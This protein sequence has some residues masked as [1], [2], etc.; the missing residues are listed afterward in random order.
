MSTT[1]RI[2]RPTTNHQHPRT[3]HTD[4]NHNDHNKDSGTVASSSSTTTLAE[5][6]QPSPAATAGDTNVGTEEPKDPP[7]STT[8]HA[9]Q[10]PLST[11]STNTTK[12]LEWM[13]LQQAIVAQPIGSMTPADWKQAH[14]WMQTPLH[15]L[16]DRY[17][18]QGKPKM[19][20][21]NKNH[22][23][24]QPPTLSPSTTSSSSSFVYKTPL[25]LQVWDRLIQEIQ[26]TTAAK[27]NSGMKNKDDSSS[28]TN[29][30]NHKFLPPWNAND[31]GG[32]LMSIL[33][34]WK[35][36]SMQAITDNNNHKNDK[37]NPN[38]NHNHNH[39]LLET[40]VQLWDRLVQASQAGLW[41][42]LDTPMVPGLLL[43]V[44]A[45]QA[46]SAQDVQDLMNQF[47]QVQADLQ[48]QQQQQAALQQQQQPESPTKSMDQ[49]DESHNN[50]NNAP[51]LSLSN[52]NNNTNNNHRPVVLVDA[53]TYKTVVL[54][55][56]RAGQ[57]H[58]CDRLVRQ[59]VQQQQ[60]L[61]AG[62]GIPS[63]TTTST[64]TV[65]TASHVLNVALT[66][67]TQQ[68][69]AQQ[70]LSNHP[71]A[72]HATYQAWTLYQDLK[73]VCTPDLVSFHSLLNILA[74][75]WRPDLVDQLFHDGQQLYQQHNRLDLRPDVPLY[76]VRLQA[77]A[78]ILT[79]A[80]SRKG[81]LSTTT[82]RKDQ[83][84]R[85]QME[86]KAWKTH[87]HKAPEQAT[88]VLREMMQVPWIG[89]QDSATSDPSKSHSD[90][91]V[92]FVDHSHNPP[93]DDK[94]KHTITQQQRQ[95][96]QG[97]R[98][99][100]A[101]DV[102]AVQGPNKLD[103][104]LVLKCWAQSKRPDAGVQAEQVMRDMLE[105]HTQLQQRQDGD[106]GIVVDCFPN[107][108]SWNHVLTAHL[109]SGAPGSLERVY[110]L[111]VELKQQQQLLLQQQPVQGTD[112]AAA[113]SLGHVDL[114]V[115]LYTTVL[116]A[117]V[118]SRDPMALERAEEL[119]QELKRQEQQQQ[120]ASSAVSSTSARIHQVDA[121][122]YQVMVQVAHERQDPQRI[123]E[124]FHEMKETRR[125]Q[126]LQYCHCLRVQSWAAAG[127][128]EHTAAALQEWSHQASLPPRIQSPDHADQQR[129]LHDGGRTK[130]PRSQDYDSVL[131]AWSHCAT[132]RPDAPAQAEAE[133]RRR[134]NQVQNPDPS[135]NT[136]AGAMELTPSVV[137]YTHVLTTLARSGA[138]QAGVQAL[139]LLRELQQLA[140]GSH[141]PNESEQALS[142]EENANYALAYRFQPSLDTYVQ[143]ISALC[144]SRNQFAVS[145]P[146]ANN[147]NDTNDNSTTTTTP[148]TTTSETTPEEAIQ[149]L[150]TELY[151]VPHPRLFGATTSSSTP[152]NAEDVI[153]SFDKMMGDIQGSLYL[154]DP[155]QKERLLQQLVP[156][157]QAIFQEQGVQGGTTTSSMVQSS[158]SSRRYPDMRAHS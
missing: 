42:P 96:R 112:A 60:Q 75:Q 71:S 146:Q 102:T 138:P 73:H 20:K 47:L 36:E 126:P 48:Q 93:Q 99:R 104:D 156:L 67:W 24:T 109:K 29:S 15:H 65:V 8:P 120:A 149:G 124:L 14:Q 66:A 125:I 62:H 11:T 139:R 52:N 91:W 132:T 57:A 140:K 88:H 6:N 116:Q 13:Q 46:A 105:Y 82:T 134:W 9:Q 68:A 43:S 50:N 136:N 59:L 31:N 4:H 122:V 32:L 141:H 152:M 81:G 131:Q 92:P 121:V 41:T 77:W 113:A 107:A 64:N 1:T 39:T 7:L 53:W 61:E 37:D 33:K 110:Q 145:T 74:K 119:F 143:V 135:S 133:L 78:T 114:D 63:S 12:S 28:T 44:L 25:V 55:W 40:P 76:R 151:N 45:H 80:S 127:Y 18:K 10:T 35:T 142:R 94:K 16:T 155:A 111:F 157:R 97:R 101:V 2:L 56:R 100:H 83:D 34:D 147:H 30:S 86:F 123:E 89:L 154:R 129:P 158:S 130:P 118:R 148:A 26:A 70:S 153:Q 90:S 23:Q 95:R 49:H 27:T 150:I 38:N 98:R 144:R 137:S 115:A 22:H 117:L 108:M 19:K 106:S 128:P 51:L 3:I 87:R 103:F 17:D 72:S 69:L 85:S 5:S 84:Y 54:A 21:H 79:A 58:H